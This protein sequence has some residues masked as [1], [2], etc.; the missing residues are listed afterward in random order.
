MVW[1]Q[2]LETGKSILVSTKAFLWG[3]EKVFWNAPRREGSGGLLAAQFCRGDNEIVGGLARNYDKEFFSA[4]NP[5]SSARVR[6]VSLD[7]VVI[8]GDTAR[9]VG[10]D[11]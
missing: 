4:S 11:E 9:P 7:L 3:F 1:L 8:D 10:V 6:C 2:L 5:S